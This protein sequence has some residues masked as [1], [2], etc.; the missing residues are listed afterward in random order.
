MDIYEVGKAVSARRLAVGL[1]QQRLA[2]LAGLSRQTVQHL[3]S[4]GDANA[5]F[6]LK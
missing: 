3:D 4:F 6:L 1:T 5:S 2:K